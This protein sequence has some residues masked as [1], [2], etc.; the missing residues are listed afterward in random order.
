MADMSEDAF[1]AELRSVLGRADVPIPAKCA[2]DI[3]NKD[4]PRRD[5]LAEFA[6][7]VIGQLDE[8]GVDKMQRLTG[9][10]EKYNPEAYVKH[11]QSELGRQTIEIS[12]LNLAIGEKEAKLYEPTDYV[13]HVSGDSQV[14]VKELDRL[15][16][17]AVVNT[18]DKINTLR[19]VINLKQGVIGRLEARNK[20]LRDNL[21][22]AEALREMEKREKLR[23]ANEQQLRKA[24]DQQNVEGSSAGSTE[25]ES[26]PADGRAASPRPP[27]KRQYAGSQHVGI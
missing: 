13:M 14:D 1:A 9:V 8:C 24:S 20:Q 18:G 22:Y 19:V 16:D 23:M 26:G 17:Y 12:E 11:L 27:M 21:D 5:R 2:L 4:G 10:V 25:D 3:V 15:A 6:F 7:S